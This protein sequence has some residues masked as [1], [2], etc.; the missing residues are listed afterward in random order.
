MLHRMMTQNKKVLRMR[1][2]ASIELEKLFQKPRSVRVDDE[3]RMYVPDFESH[4]VQIYQKEA[5]PLS[6]DQIASPY[7]A[8]T[9]S[10]N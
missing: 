2:S 1:E 5:Y 3:G 9:L 4:R 8:R 10:V 6:E 7:R